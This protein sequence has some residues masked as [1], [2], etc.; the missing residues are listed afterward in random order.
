MHAFAGRAKASLVCKVFLE[1]IAKTFK[2]H[3][4]APT[5]RKKVQAQFD[6]SSWMVLHKLN[7]KHSL[8]YQQDFT[9]LNDG[10]ASRPTHPPLNHWTN[11]SPGLVFQHSTWLLKRPQS[12]AFKRK[13]CATPSLPVSKQSCTFC[14]LTTLRKLFLPISFTLSTHT[15]TTLT[16]FK[17]WTKTSTSVSESG[18]HQTKN[19][20]KGNRYLW[21]QQ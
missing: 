7:Q 16:L 5:S 18:H 8:S 2:E 17:S 19:A 6:I 1:S 9:S 12:T 3:P 10:E 4:K 20:L 14:A 21:G 13:N 11:T 15:R